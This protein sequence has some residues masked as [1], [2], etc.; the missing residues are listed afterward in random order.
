MKHAWKYSKYIPYM[1]KFPYV[2]NAR[3][4]QEKAIMEFP[5]LEQRNNFWSLFT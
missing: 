3:E 4:S 2:D 1:D 5:C